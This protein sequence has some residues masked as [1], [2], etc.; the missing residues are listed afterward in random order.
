MEARI[1]DLKAKSN[2][3]G[4]VYAPNVDVVLRANA[5]V[6]GSF[7]AKDFEFK[8]GGNMY[9]DKALRTVSTDDEGVRF[10]MNRWSE[11]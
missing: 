8:N 1:F 10:V 6:Y 11:R 5:D 9:Y 4:G 3:S 2:W 7:V